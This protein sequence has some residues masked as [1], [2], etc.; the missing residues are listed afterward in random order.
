MKP[1]N[2][3]FVFP[4]HHALTLTPWVISSILALFTA[5]PMPVRLLLSS[6]GNKPVRVSIRK[7]NKQL[8]PQWLIS[9]KIEN[10]YWYY[11]FIK[12]EDQQ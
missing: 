7:C 12:H 6:T 1:A 5:N 3:Y 8:H 11:T 2:L 4:I 10:Y 9:P